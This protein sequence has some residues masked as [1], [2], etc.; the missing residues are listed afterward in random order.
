MALGAKQSSFYGNFQMETS[1]ERK[2]QKFPEFW[3][4]SREDVNIDIT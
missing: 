2:V 1:Q 3:S 4:E